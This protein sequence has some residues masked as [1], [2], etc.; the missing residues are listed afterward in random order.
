MPNCPD[1]TLFDPA[2]HLGGGDRFRAA[3]VVTAGPAGAPPAE[4]VATRAVVAAPPERD[5]L[6]AWQAAS[7]WQL[8]DVLREAAPDLGCRTR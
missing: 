5:A 8:P 7:A 1:R 4:A 3:V 6:Q 2:Q